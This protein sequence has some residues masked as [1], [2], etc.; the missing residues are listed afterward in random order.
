M[1]RAAPTG[2]SNMNVSISVAKRQDYGRSIEAL[3]RGYQSRLVA[4]RGSNL[5]CRVADQCSKEFPGLRPE[6]MAID[7]LQLTQTSVLRLSDL[8]RAR[9]DIDA[10]ILRLRRQLRS[11]VAELPRKAERA[12]GSTPG[13]T[14]SA[15][16]G[17]AG[18]T[19]AVR[20]VLL[21]F[22]ISLTPVSVR[23][24]LPCVGFDANR[25]K[26]PLTSIHSILRRLVATGEVLRTDRLPDTPRYV[27]ADYLRESSDEPLRHNSESVQCR[28]PARIAKTNCGDSIEDRPDMG[29]NQERKLQASVS[30]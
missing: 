20:R 12:A 28:M 22:P 9:R 18:V 3:R 14:P 17:C 16:M 10:K 15:S 24:L 6:F 1:G 26:H 25:Y 29:L 19:D 8:V 23:D 30:Q 21:T 11:A 4:K 2:Y 5:R 7:Y 13:S 27:W